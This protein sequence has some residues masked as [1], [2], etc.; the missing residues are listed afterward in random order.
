MLADVSTTRKL[1]R[2]DLVIRL[3]FGLGMKKQRVLYDVEPPHLNTRIQAL[4]HLLAI[5]LA[6]VFPLDVG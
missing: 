4:N 2:V 1:A 6:V 3:W 5:K